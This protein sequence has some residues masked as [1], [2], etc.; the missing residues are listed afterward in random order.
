[1]H[2]LTGLLAGKVGLVVGIANSQSIA[3]GCADA[4]RNAGAQLAITYP[5]ERSKP[6]VEAASKHLEPTLFVPLD[7]EA[8]GERE[9]VFDQ[10]KA[11]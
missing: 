1:M 2:P 10:I 5:N 9:A 6:F 11:T 7:V 8:A 3:A 4:F